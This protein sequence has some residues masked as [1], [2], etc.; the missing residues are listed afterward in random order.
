MAIKEVAKRR[1]NYG[2]AGGSDASRQ[3]W[4]TGQMAIKEVAKRR[5]NHGLAGGSDASC[6]AWGDRP[7]GHQRGR[8]AAYQLRPGRWARR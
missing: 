5:T 8:E 3:A 6:Q 2:L 4:G 7:D 1:T